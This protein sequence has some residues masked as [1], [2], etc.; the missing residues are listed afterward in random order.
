MLLLNK[1]VY[2]AWAGSTH[3]WMAAYD[4]TTLQQ[5]PRSPL[6]RTATSADCGPAAAESFRMEPIFLWKPETE[7]LT[8]KIREGFRRLHGQTGPEYPRHTRLLHSDGPE[9]PP[10]ERHGFRFW[11]PNADADPAWLPSKRNRGFGK[12]RNALRSLSMA[13]ITHWC[14]WSTRIAWA[15][16]TR[17]GRIWIFR[18]LRARFTATTAARLILEA[19]PAPGLPGWIDFRG[20]RG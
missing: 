15:A 5:L 2:M 13:A 4:A 16:T 7:P 12:R 19:R 6:L 9:L 3:G 20:G 10:A 18:R 8:L 14:I 1:I 11:R 17:T